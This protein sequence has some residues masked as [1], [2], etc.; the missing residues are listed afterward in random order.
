[1]REVLEDYKG[2]LQTGG[3]RVTNVR[4]ADDIILLACLEMQ[5]QE[6]V[7]RLKRV[8]GKCDVYDEGY[9]NTSSHIHKLMK[10]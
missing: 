4:Y 2:G 10:N 1:M 3:W 6:L 8:S 9:C 5:L 7:D